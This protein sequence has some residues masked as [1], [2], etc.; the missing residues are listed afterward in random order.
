M[1]TKTYILLVLFGTYLNKDCL[2]LRRPY[3]VGQHFLKLVRVL[4]MNINVFF[5]AC[6][7][8]KG[9]VVT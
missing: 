6:D 5:F 1:C 3:I 4:I 7:Q 8:H 2:N 9:V